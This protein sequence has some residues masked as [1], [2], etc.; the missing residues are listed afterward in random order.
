MIS[1]TQ[2]NRILNRYFG[3]IS[4]T[5][6]ST[7]YIGLS[8]TPI[9]QDGTGYTEPVGAGYAR[10]AISNNKTTF[11]T[12]TA[13][14]LYNAVEIQ[15]SESTASWGNITHIFIADTISGAPIYYDALPAP[16]A[17]QAQSVLLFSPNSITIRTTSV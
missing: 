12:S 13:G 10:V 3:N 1:N 5:V 14:V 8:T 4:D 2:G 15:F 6:A 16:R 17:V 9:N 11:T 7:L